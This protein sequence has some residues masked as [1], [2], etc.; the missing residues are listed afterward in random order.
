[1]KRGLVLRFVWLQSTDLGDQAMDGSIHLSGSE[2]KALLK[3]VRG[4]DKVRTARRAHVVLLAAAGWSY[5]QM[6]QVLFASNDLIADSLTRFRQG[7]IAALM[8]Q[9]SVAC[10]VVPHWLLRVVDW[11]RNHTPQD[12]SYFRSRWSCQTLAELLWWE[13]GVRRSA[14]TVRRGLRRLGYVWRRP[15]PAVGPSDPDYAQKLGR[16]RR[17]LE[18]LSPREVAVFQD[19]VDIHLNPKIGSCWMPRGQQA[20]VTTPGN[21][22]K[23]HLAGSLNWR[24][25]TLFVST[26][27]TRRDARLFVNHLDDLRRRLRT[28]GK[29]HVILDNARFHDCRLVRNYLARWGHRIQLHFLPKYAPETNPIERVWWHLHETITRNHRKQT[30]E[31]LLEETIHWFDA[32]RRFPVEKGIYAA[33]A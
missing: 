17:L 19:E 5:R 6:R 10:R 16:I 2:R 14:E 30:I 7:G 25:G 32:Q 23:R 21:N 29:I 27:S 22:Q 1:M 26:P 33:V 12:F 31:E 24:T 3:L 18:N 15:R 8:E 13:E 20:Q 4:G 28:Y 9:R 11:V